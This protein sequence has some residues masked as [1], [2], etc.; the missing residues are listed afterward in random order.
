M[1]LILTQHVSTTT[2]TT[3]EATLDQ[4]RWLVPDVLVLG[5]TAF[6]TEAG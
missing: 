2:T 4:E 6:E 3:M 5:G 1:T